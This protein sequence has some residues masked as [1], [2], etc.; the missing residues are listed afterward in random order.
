MSGCF[1]YNTSMA[2]SMI[3]RTTA[4]P[5]AVPS[6]Q[7]VRATTILTRPPFHPS[8]HTAEPG[9]MQRSS[10]CKCTPKHAQRPALLVNATDLTSTS[11]S[12]ASMLPS[13]RRLGDGPYI[14]LH[15][16]CFLQVPSEPGHIAIGRK[17]KALIHPS[18]R[19]IP[20]SFLAPLNLP[21]SGP[22]PNDNRVKFKEIADQS[23]TSPRK[24]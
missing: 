14:P 19:T 11:V 13:V 2:D 1:V 24:K 5:R 7:S 12:T 18:I 23:N 15:P 3:I 16:S 22:L 21:T 20:I 10:S 9:I 6:L 17:R 4:S 8:P